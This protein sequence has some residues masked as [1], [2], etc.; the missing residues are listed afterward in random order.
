MHCLRVS[1]ALDLGARSSHYLCSPLHHCISSHLT[2]RVIHHIFFILSTVRF[3]SSSFTP[4]GDPPHFITW[5]VVMSFPLSIPRTLIQGS[6]VW[7]G[8]LIRLSLWYIDIWEHVY[9]FLIPSLGSSLYVFRSFTVHLYV[10][11]KKKKKNMWFSIFSHNQHNA[12][13]NQWQTEENKE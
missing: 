6:S 12:E 5:R 10:V 3:T 7:E 8:H 2:V 4:W 9:S 11:K 13:N 1:W